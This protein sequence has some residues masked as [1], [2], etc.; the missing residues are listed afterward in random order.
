MFTGTPPEFE[1]RVMQEGI[2][3]HQVQSARRPPY[4]AEQTGQARCRTELALS[5][6]EGGW[7]AGFLRP[8]AFHHGLKKSKPHGDKARR[9][10]HYHKY[11][12]LKLYAWMTAC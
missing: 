9:R 8:G 10:P 5:K 2:R 12:V 1:L 6:F 4:V 11:C 3:T 7:M